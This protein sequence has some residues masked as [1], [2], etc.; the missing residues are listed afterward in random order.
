MAGIGLATVVVLVV[1]GFRLVA[2]EWLVRFEYGRDGFPA[3]RYGLTTEERTTLA[4]VGLESIRPGGDGTVLLDR[5]T[6]PDGSAAFDRREIEHMG[7]VRRLLGVALRL[8]LVLALALVVLA[9]VL[10]RTWLRTAVPA[11]LLSGALGTLGI[12]AVAVPFVVLGFDG[13]FVR[14]HEIFFDGDTWRFARTDTLLRLYP[15]RFWQDTAQLIAGLTLAQAVVLA[16]LAWLW[17]RR[18][19]RGG[20][21]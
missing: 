3:D 13:L 17:L 19:R 5:A 11:G 9:L 15:D 16:P 18:A 4:L 21:G 7:D 8:Q 6:L 2:A 10:H 1:N 20:A 12:A 14:F